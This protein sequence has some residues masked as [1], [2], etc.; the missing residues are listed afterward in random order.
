MYLLWQVAAMLRLFRVP[1]ISYMATSPSL[2]DPD[3]FPYFFR[4]V[5]SDY[6]QAHAM[7]EI[8]KYA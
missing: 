1:Q 4:T 3:R 7:L 8:L 6:N 2:S 5:P